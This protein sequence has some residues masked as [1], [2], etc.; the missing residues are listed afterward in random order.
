MRMRRALCLLVLAGAITTGVEQQADAGGFWLPGR[1]V[2][3]MG[4]GAAFVAGVDDLHAVWYNPAGLASLAGEAPAIG[5]VKRQ[6]WS[7]LLDLALV[8][9]SSSF[10]RVITAG[11][12]PQPQAKVENGASPQVI[13]TLGVGHA[14]SDRLAGAVVLMAP[15]AGLASFPADG[16]QRYSAVNGDGTII[17][18]LAVGAGYKVGEHLRLGATVQNMFV[19]YESIITIS[20]CPSETI[21][22]PEDPEFDAVG[23]AAQNGFFNPTASV[24]LQVAYPKFRGGL[25][26]QLPTWVH[27]S[28]QLDVRLPS[29]AFFDGARMQGDQAST[30]FT[31]PATLRAGVEVRPSRAL[32]AEVAAD[33][34]MWGAHEDVTVTPDN[35]RIEDVPSVGTYDLSAQVVPRNFQNVLALHVGG[36]AALGRARA[37]A[38]RAGYTFEQGAPPPEWLSPLTIDTNKHVLALGGGWRSK[39][40]RLGIDAVFGYVMQP[41]TT[42]TDSQQRQLTGIRQRDPADPAPPVV[43]NGN[44]TSSWLFFGVGVSYEIGARAAAP[45]PSRA[46]VTEDPNEDG[47]VDAEAEPDGL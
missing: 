17:A 15:Y 14:F 7:A 3:P 22:A 2:R 12:T 34:E 38:L 6:Q 46:P 41:D 1:G 25:S 33:Y 24:G 23:H 30:E 37:I 27:A 18:S 10:Q 16:P 43:A 28:G 13:P 44:Y 36:E 21:C 29:A 39:S 9:N 4:R 26:F 40:G 45:A 19:H 8:K 42:I 47:G 35:V 20:S 32:R 5:D 31:L 11:T